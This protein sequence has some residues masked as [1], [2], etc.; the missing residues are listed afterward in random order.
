LNGSRPASEPIVTPMSL[1]K[2]FMLKHIVAR[3][4]RT[5]T[6]SVF[7]LTEL[8]AGNIVPSQAI[9]PRRQKLQ[10]HTGEEKPLTSNR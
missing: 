1:R 8:G 10:A 3:C 9:E 2:S 5:T 6:S 4:R 7:P